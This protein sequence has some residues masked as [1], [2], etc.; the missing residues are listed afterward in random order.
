MEHQ[1]E[2]DFIPYTLIGFDLEADGLEPHLA[3]I[4]QIG[5]ACCH[6]RVSLKTGAF[7]PQKQAVQDPVGGWD[8]STFSEF[9]YTSQELSEKVKDITKITP[10]QVL[11][12]CSFREVL[13]Q[14]T[15]W[16]QARVAE[17]PASE[18]Q[19]HLHVASFVTYNGLGYD[20]PLMAHHL[21]RCPVNV[22]AWFD[23][24]GITAHLDVLKL[25]ASTWTLNNYKQTFVYPEVFGKPLEGA[26]TAAID[27]V[28]TLRLL[29]KVKQDF[30]TGFLG[31]DTTLFYL[32]RDTSLA[33]SKIYDPNTRVFATPDVLEFGSVK[34]PLHFGAM[35]PFRTARLQGEQESKHE[36]HEEHETWSSD[37]DPEHEHELE[38]E[39]EY[40]HE[41]EHEHEDEETPEDIE[42]MEDVEDIQ[43]MCSDDNDNGEDDED[44]VDSVRDNEAEAA[45]S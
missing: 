29:L 20:M 4:I 19:K 26:H 5:A 11:T 3:P 44:D 30:R 1:A 33:R 27:A 35:V 36:E 40:A 14:F 12:A 41:R 9:V 31:I 8:F 42:D 21:A 6:G 2:A 17:N 25:V 13:G 45:F 38:H 10:E 39:P 28:A 15:L 32:F 37:R 24:L 34:C 16:V 7:H 43:Y 22:Q 18:S 23:L